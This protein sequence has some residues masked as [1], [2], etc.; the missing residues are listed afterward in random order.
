MAQIPKLFSAELDGIEAELIEVE[1]DLNVG[2]HSFNIVGLGDKAVSEAKERV[3]SA[4]KNCNI[5]PPTR[6]NRR[7][8]VNLAPADVKKVGSRFDVPITLAYLLAS[9]Q[10][11][12]FET[13]DKLFVGELS[14]DGTIRPVQGIINIALLAR[15][16]GIKFLFVPKENA[17]E[18]AVVHELEVISVPHLSFLIDYLEGRGEASPHPK[19]IPK[20]E[21][22]PSLVE[23]MDIK[24]HEGAKRSLLIAAAGGHNLFMS[25]PPGTGKTILAQALSS[26]LPPPSYDEIVEIT[27]VYSAAGLNAHSSIIT[28]RPF[29]MPHHSSS[30]VAVVGGGTSPRPGEISLAHRGVLFLDEVPEFHRD[31]LEALRQPLESGAIHIARAKKT[32]SFPARFML[33]GAM[34]PCPCGYFADTQKECT[35][36]AH[37]V[38]QYQKK[39]S[40][41]LLDR[42]DLQLTVERIA[43]EELQKTG[44]DSAEQ[45]KVKEKVIRARELQ[46]E[47]F[48]DLPEVYTNAE[49]PSKH[50]DTFLLCEPGVQTVLQKIFSKHV[51]SARGY[52][53]ILKVARTIA[54]LEES[55]KIT[56]L[57]VA[58]AFQYRL[59]AS[60]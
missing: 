55:K 8:T 10:I 39:I 36:T 30:L 44:K 54:D 26:I 60:E 7:I 4:L 27:K 1:A 12:P 24:G 58:E 28:Y 17:Y 23:F 29:R 33:V 20:P 15:N 40:G 21:T 2:L 37:S 18:A 51:L 57:H 59:R 53:R 13:N 49:L 5:K 46:R 52:Y 45:S 42:M 19:T 43:L 16:K 14:L 25:G 22:Q 3:N 32:L 50:T 31:V 47:R 9:E 56:P 6:E 35:C 34:N 11:K 41:P 48:H 38:A